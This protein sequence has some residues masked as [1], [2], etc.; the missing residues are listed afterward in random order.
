MIKTVDINSNGAKH[1][2]G[3]LAKTLAKQISSVEQVK[4]Q[5]QARGS[6]QIKILIPQ[7]ISSF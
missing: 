4:Y 6:E 7:V 3:F 5:F 1:S 2:N